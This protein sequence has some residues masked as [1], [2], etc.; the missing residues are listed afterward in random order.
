MYSPLDEFD[1]AALY[2]DEYSCKASPP[3]HCYYIFTASIMHIT[4]RAFVYRRL[5]SVLTA[6]SV[7]AFPNDPQARVGLGTCMNILRAI[8]VVWPSAGRAL[9]LLKGSKVNSSNNPPMVQLPMVQLPADRRKRPFIKISQAPSY[10]F[11]SE[12]SPLAYSTP[13]SPNTNSDYQPTLPPIQTASNSSNYY[14]RW[15]PEH[16]FDNVQYNGSLTTSVLPQSYSTGFV[17]ERT[18]TLHDHRSQISPTA[19]HHSQRVYPPHYWD[20]YNEYPTLNT[21][22]SYGHSSQHSQQIP[23]PSSVPH[24]PTSHL[25]L[26]PPY[27]YSTSAHFPSMTAL[28]RHT[29]NSDHQ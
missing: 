18:T 3:Y 15:T 8:E 1:S 21:Q 20:D 25:F 7:S 10:S 27:H 12:P 24:T 11:T 13:Y 5:Y 6:S 29:D 26:H 19:L 17:D 2:L 28:T 22:S 9:E 4:A 23:S 14:Q 16:H